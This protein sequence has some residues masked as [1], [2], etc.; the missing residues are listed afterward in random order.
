MAA[1][2]ELKSQALAPGI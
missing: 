2:P 1:E